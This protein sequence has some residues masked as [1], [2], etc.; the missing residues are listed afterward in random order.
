M[1]RITFFHMYSQPSALRM[2]LFR[3]TSGSPPSSV[4]AGQ[5]SLQKYGAPCPII[6]TRNN[7]S[8][9]TNTAKI[10]Y[11][12][13]RSS[14]SPLNVRIFLGNGILFNKSWIS[15]KAEKTA[16]QPSHHSSDEDKK[17][18]HIISHFEIPAPYHRLKGTNRTGANSTG[19]GITVQARN[20]GIFQFA[21]VNFAC[22]KTGNMTVC[23]DA[24]SA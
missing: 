13:L 1:T 17:S 14:L 10:T 3:S 2:D 23:N 11:F 24:H 21:C 7:G 22:D 6:S 4:P 18:H 9:I 19:T 5:I 8:R 15:P 12:S 20:T 16:D